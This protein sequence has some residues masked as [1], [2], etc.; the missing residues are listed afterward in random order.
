MG[1]ENNGCFRCCCGVGCAVCWIFIGIWGVIMLG[2]LAILFASGK[3]GNIGDFDD[4][5]NKKHATTLF[6]VAGIYLVLTVFC[7]WNLNYRLKH[8]FPPK[9]GS[10]PEDKNAQV[11]QIGAVHPDEKLE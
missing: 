2:I 5:D 10:E 8:P 3:K 6:V 4:K 9:A 11:A 7:S 1:L